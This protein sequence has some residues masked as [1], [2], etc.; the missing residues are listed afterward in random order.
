[1]P[2]GLRDAIQEGFFQRAT[3]Q[4]MAGGVPESR[5]GLNDLISQLTAA[6]RAAPRGTPHIPS[7]GG[8]GQMD[9]IY[10]AP[11]QPPNATMDSAGEWARYR[12]QL[13]GYS[14]DPF[15]GRARI[16]QGYSQ[17]G[18]T[19]AEPSP[20][21]SGLAAALTMA[22]GMERTD[23]DRQRLGL[24]QRKFDLLSSPEQA[25]QRAAASLL[26]ISARTG[27]APTLEQRRLAAEAE[28]V[29]GPPLTA[30]EIPEQIGLKEADFAQP[31]LIGAAMRGKQF[32][33]RQINLLQKKLAETKQPKDR[34]PGVGGR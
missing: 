4:Q 11:P 30:A 24:E 15:G 19:P 2:Y 16:P 13:A 18:A 1:M 23:I 27:A 22:P 26:N 3:P 31:E 25:R 32:T 17:V 7:Y 8:T 34:P 5:G 29:P 10:A 21:Q 33:P 6:Y 20:E 28:G 14:L 12:G 9:A